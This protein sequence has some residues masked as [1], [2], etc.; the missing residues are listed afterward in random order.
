MRPMA[1]SLLILPVKGCEGHPEP[2]RLVADLVERYQPVVLIEG[3][4]LHRF[5]HYRAGVLL[6]L[7]GK[8]AYGV[9]V[10]FGLTFGLPSQQYI[11][12][13]IEDGGINRLTALLGYL[14]RP[15]DVADIISRT[16]TIGYIS[17]IDRKIGDNLGKCAVLTVEG[18]IACTA[19]A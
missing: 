15:V 6:V 13:E 2:L 18:E 5:G 9:P 10:C 1:R 8:G 12:H 3:R 16:F 19:V 17:T 4:I 14:N 7:H 11:P